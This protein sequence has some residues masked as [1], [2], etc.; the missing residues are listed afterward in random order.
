MRTRHA[1]V[2]LPLIR[3]SCFLYLQDFDAVPPSSLKSPQATKFEKCR[4]PLDT[5]IIASHV[6]APD[7]QVQRG[8]SVLLFQPLASSDSL[9]LRS[10][11]DK[12]KIGTRSQ[13]NNIAE[14]SFS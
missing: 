5:R 14:R 12:N 4:S 7:A 8:V 13:G 11:T 2:S 3:Q 10:K 9:F 1:S 6:I